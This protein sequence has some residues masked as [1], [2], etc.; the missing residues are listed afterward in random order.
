MQ[1]N[2]KQIQASVPYKSVWVGASAGTGKTKILVDRIIRLLLEEVDISKILCITYTKAAAEE[3]KERL[4][5]ILFR[6]QLATQNEIE[7]DIINMMGK[8]PHT[9][10]IEKAQSLHSIVY[11]N[12]NT[13]HIQTIHSL[14]QSILM[15]FS[16]ESSVPEHFR[17]LAS[18]EYEALISLIKQQ[19]FFDKSLVDKLSFMFKHLHDITTGKLIE[20]ICIYY[21]KF[22]KFF[23]AIPDIKQYQKLLSTLLD[24]KPIDVVWNIFNSYQ[25][26]PTNHYASDSDRKVI[27]KYNFFISASSSE[28]FI[29]SDGI[30][31]SFLTSKGEKRSRLLSKKLQKEAPNL[32]K[33]LIK[34]QEDIY[35]L[36]QKL[37]DLRLLEYSSQFYDF[38][39]LVITIYEKHKN[40]HRLLGYDEIIDKTLI[41]F[42]ES[43]LKDWVLYKLDGGFNHVL[44]DEAQDTNP[45]QWEIIKRLV[46]E[47][48]TGESG[49][50]G[51]S[52]FIVGDDKQSIY[53]FQGADPQYY[54]NL[55]SFFRKKIIDAKQD[56]LS[57]DLDL[58][59]RSG[60]SIIIAVDSVMKYI[61]SQ[62]ADL[63]SFQYNTASVHKLNLRARVE[64]WP[65]ERAMQNKSH[66]SWPLPEELGN[67]D[68]AKIKLC[69]NIASYI[70]KEVQSGAQNFSDIMILV[71][72]RDEFIN[73]LIEVFDTE[74][75][76]HYGLD[77]INIMDDI[78]VKDIVA[79]AKF[80]IF[81]HDDLNLASLLLSPI[82]NITEQELLLLAL[83]REESLW[84]VVKDK[85]DNLYWQ[86]NE[87]IELYKST[88]FLEFFQILF[89][90]TDIKHKLIEANGKLAKDTI[91]ELFHLIIEYSR[92]DSMTSLQEFLLELEESEMLLTRA[93]PKGNY[94]N[95]S[96]VHGSKGLESKTVILVDNGVLPKEQGNIHW[97][98]NFM[99]FPGKSTNISSKTKL[100]ISN[101]D[102]I[103]SEYLRLLYVAMTRSKQH[104]VICGYSN[105][106][107]HEDSWYNICYQALSKVAKVRD[108]KLVIENTGD[109]DSNVKI[110]Q[111]D[112]QYEVALQQKELDTSANE[113]SN[114]YIHQPMNKKV[115]EY[116]YVFHQVLETVIKHISHNQTINVIELTNDVN[117]KYRLTIQNKLEQLLKHE[118][119][120]YLVQNYRL[121]PE[122]SFI[123][124]NKVGRMD[125]LCLRKEDL[126]ILD[127]KTDKIVPSDIQ[128]IQEGHIMQLK[129]Y[130]Q[131]IQQIYPDHRIALKLLWLE[132]LTFMDINGN[133]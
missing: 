31:R 75:I 33:Q 82:C 84:N 119:F 110:N 60:S 73:Q 86:L 42:S 29:L 74:S 38:A 81:P 105:S 108:D 20:E 12:N 116:G 63:A 133:P 100:L 99:I 49:K 24:I 3:M 95:I 44:V 66:I 23:T 15:R 93:C 5:G 125:L 21:V 112:G 109:E 22:E 11:A 35:N 91:N 79:I 113:L 76:N 130:K 67:E 55:Y 98:Q 64:V 115:I 61:K 107:I 62:Y 16:L 123:M 90:S 106:N 25:T 129:L 36:H 58:S 96:T 70:L 2:S 54:Q 14:C 126:I 127:Y 47:F 122:L 39:K 34:F 121:Y 40:Y 69:K 6:W 118:Y 56:F 4:E 28:R 71:R 88:D 132:N 37:K 80:V 97:I 46:E 27:G 17:I 65:I 13:I 50:I 53:S 41:L 59:Y 92:R 30:Y 77:R 8:L 19:I 45:Q 120:Q 89:Q 68:D 94:V 102:N 83:D 48:F 131:A 78:S 72:K 57:I 43:E 85:K 1:Q 128:Y 104:L 9:Q 18:Q 114:I 7:S 10:I 52:L 87:Y 101:K 26:L 103:M 32:L 111:Y 51:R 117:H 124:N